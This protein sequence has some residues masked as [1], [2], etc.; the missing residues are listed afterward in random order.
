MNRRQLAGSIVSGSVVTAFGG[1]LAAQTPESAEETREIIDARGTQVI[2]ADP[3][4]V[5]S[6][7]EEPLLA[8]LLELGI[9]PIAAG[10]NYE[11][12]YIGIDPALTEGLE[13]MILWELDIE[14]LTL[15]PMD[16]ILVPE[17]FYTLNQQGFDLI[18]QLAP[19]VVLPTHADW[20]EN[21]TYLASVFGKE[22]DAGQKIADLESE[23]AQTAEDLAIEG[24][25]ATYATIYPAA[26]E[27]TLWLTDQLPIV[28]VG[29][30]LG[31]TVVPDGADYETDQAGRARISLEQ[32]Q[33]VQGDTLLMLQTTGGISAEEDQSYQELLESTAFQLLPAVQADRVHIIERVGFPGDIP[34]RRNLLVRYR[35]IFG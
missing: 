25:T 9:T 6:L 34:G 30:E 29:V 35:E 17:G 20:R 27:L 12:V 28:E 15:L 14:A 13:P 32:V 10:G 7:G 1:P 5:V 2:P 18:G 8:D 23:I 31:L 4:A 19:M 33:V 22:D 21:F 11:G 26:S 16:L 24:Q 3:Q